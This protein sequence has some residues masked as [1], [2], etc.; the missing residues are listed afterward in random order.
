MFPLCWFVAGR[1]RL[2]VDIEPTAPNAARETTIEHTAEQRQPKTYTPEPMRQN[3]A[4]R[5]AHRIE[6]MTVDDL[7]RMPR[8][9]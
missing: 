3:T 2:R 6:T 9:A 4:S 5:P 7:M 8:A 1:N